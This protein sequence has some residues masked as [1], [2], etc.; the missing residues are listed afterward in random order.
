[1]PHVRSDSLSRSFL[2]WVAA[3]ALFAPALTAQAA[4]LELIYT[5]AF[6]SQEALNQASA[7]SPTHFNGLTPFTIVAFFDDSSPNLAPNF[8]GPFNGFRAYAP[9][10]ATIVVAGAS[11]RIENITA[12]PT[13]GV[14]VAIFDRNSFDPGH[15]AVG[16]I[17]DPVHDGAGVVGDFLS[18]SPDFTA[19]AIV[20]TLFGDFFG[21]GHA[22]GVCDS[23]TAPDCPHL[24]TPWVLR[25]AANVAWNLTFGNYEADYPAAHNPGAPLS[26]LNTAQ[27][28]AVPEPSTYGLMLAGLTALGCVARRRQTRRSRD[29]LTG[30]P[31]R[32]GRAPTR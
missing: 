24:V 5:G 7:G 17:A 4:P 23:G 9:S 26:P 25:D 18:A 8:G 22:S 20:P 31:A 30:S 11:Y 32:A 12:N 19:A 1:M 14:T 13:A 21:V 16:L 27:I 10:F 2:R 15:Y 28:V 29:D 3:A 6:N